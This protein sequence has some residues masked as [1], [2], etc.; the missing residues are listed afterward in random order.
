MDQ[1]GMYFITICTQ[2]RICSL[3]SIV[4][5]EQGT[6]TM[7][8]TSIGQRVING[9]L[10]IPQFT[11][12]VMLDSFQLM[13][14]HLHGVLW[15]CKSDYNDWQP[16]VFGPQHQ[17]LAAIIRGFKAGVSA[18]AKANQIDFGWQPRFYDRVIGNA[19][20]LNRIRQYIENN[21]TK[22]QED[23]NNVEGLYM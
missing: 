10:T 20:E 23:R 9:W 2:N 14:N 16:N 5:D 7:K 1:N 8:H 11:P 18:F 4:T 15:I 21:P 17:N 3:G 19:D 22:W 12:F 6:C 13:P